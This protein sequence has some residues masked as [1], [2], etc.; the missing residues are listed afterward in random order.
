MRSIVMT[1]EDEAERALAIEVG[2]REQA[3]VQRGRVAAAGPTYVYSRISCR[4]LRG[5]PC[6]A[7]GI[8][9]GFRVS[10]VAPG[11]DEQHASDWI[12]AL[13]GGEGTR[14]QDY[15]R[16]RF[17]WQLPK[18]CCP[19]LGSRSALQHTLVRL[20]HLTPASRTSP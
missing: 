20:N 11:G 7:M 10:A 9:D 3:D 17:G 15:V 4:Y 12:L 18:Q 13:A 19:L 16:R 8:H 5:A 6:W 14:L 2:H 1:G